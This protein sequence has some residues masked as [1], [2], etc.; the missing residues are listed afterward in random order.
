MRWRQLQVRLDLESR[1][2]TYQLLPPLGNLAR[3]LELALAQLLLLAPE[4]VLL[5]PGADGRAVS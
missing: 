1:I 2:R 5:E 4:L 3:N